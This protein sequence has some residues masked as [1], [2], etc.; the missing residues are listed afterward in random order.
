MN[1]LLGSD[2][3][4]PAGRP[5]WGLRIAL[6]TV[7]VVLLA[8]LLGPAIA[9]WIRAAVFTHLVET[10]ADETRWNSR[11]V[12][13]AVLATGLPFLWA[14]RYALLPHLPGITRKQ[15][16]AKSWRRWAAYACLI[17]YSALFYLVTGF[18]TRDLYFDRKG[19]PLKYCIERPSELYCED[20]PGV[21]PYGAR[22][23]PVTSEMADRQRLRKHGELPRRVTFASSTALDAGQ[24][25]GLDG[26]PR[27]WFARALTGEIE[28]FNLPGYHPVTGQA[29]E[30]VSTE[31]LRSH[32][33]Q[34]V[35]REREEADR[36]RVEAE[37]QAEL[38]RQAEAERQAAYA[39]RLEAFLEAGAR[40]E[41]EP[42]RP[43]ASPTEPPAAQ[44]VALSL[45]A[46][47]APSGGAGCFV[48]RS[49]LAEPISVAVEREGRG[50]GDVYLPAGAT[51]RV[52]GALGREARVHVPA[53]PRQGW[54]KDLTATAA[55]SPDC[56][57]D[58]LLQKPLRKGD[59]IRLVRSPPATGS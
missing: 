7:A 58:L 4:A 34:L 12:M 21:D 23:A 39:Q 2:A 40:W 46:I 11:L 6:G 30:G 43:A 18:A 20:R 17:G 38:E 44:P 22:L 15:R 3:A 16:V 52:E 50:F 56:T 29:L 42:E 35:K 45:T 36:L 24:F 54:R 57:S 28:F 5:R 47:V 9:W 32:R 8:L 13:A 53:N 26:R 1:K 33:V 55:T 37:R 59:P 31:L 41:V 10:I 25:F 19:K 51:V 48:L 27:I 49:E 14:L